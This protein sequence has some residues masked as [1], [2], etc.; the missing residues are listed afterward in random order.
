M[1]TGILSKNLRLK[2][3]GIRINFRSCCIVKYKYKAD[4]PTNSPVY[5]YDENVSGVVE[6][7]SDSI[8]SFSSGAFI[9]NLP[10][11]RLDRKSVV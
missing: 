6:N 2:I 3:I 8:G 5:P 10:M 1:T 11:E 7:N 4:P 9:R